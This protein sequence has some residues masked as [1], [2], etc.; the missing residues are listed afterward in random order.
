MDYA[1]KL[2]SWAF[3]LARVRVW[4]FTAGIVG[5]AWMLAPKRFWI[6]VGLLLLPRILHQKVPD[7]YLSPFAF[8]YSL[9]ARRLASNR[10]MSGRDI[11]T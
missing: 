10:T 7:P 4:G 6:T 1:V 3:L 11:I 8:R 5:N 2:V 9:L